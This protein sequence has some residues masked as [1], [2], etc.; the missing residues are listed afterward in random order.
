MQVHSLQSYRVTVLVAPPD[1]E[2]QLG[3]TSTFGLKA[4][5]FGHAIAAAH[6]VSKLPVRCVV[7]Q[8]RGA[9]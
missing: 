2:N 9:A 1:G 5:S 6:A 7:R 4:T 8:D 3:I